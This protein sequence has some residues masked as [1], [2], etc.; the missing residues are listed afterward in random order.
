MTR[1]LIVADASA[2][3]VLAKI[4]RLNLLRVQYGTIVIGPVLEKEVVTAGRLQRADGMG[5]I[6]QALARRWL[7]IVNLTASERRHAANLRKNGNLDAG[8]AEA[9]SIASGRH[10]RVVVDDKEARHAAEALGL[11][12]IGT[13]GV[14]LEAHREGHLTQE[15]AE[16]TIVNLTAILWLSPSVVARALKIV[17]EKHP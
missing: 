17:Q 6:E 14:L 13:I 4:G 12:Y 7:R 11:S 1:S 16:D 10:L 9:L 8:E 5:E 3:I 2:L 15:E